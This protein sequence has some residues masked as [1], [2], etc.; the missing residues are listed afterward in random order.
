[1]ATEL[2]KKTQLEWRRHLLTD[3]GVEGMLFLREKIPS[4]LKGPADEMIFDAGRTQG[5][6]DAIDAIS[7][8]IAVAPKQDVNVEND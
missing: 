2:K 8:I 6:K 1:M 5:F 7:E 4:I 3:S